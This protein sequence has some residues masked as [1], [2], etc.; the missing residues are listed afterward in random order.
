MKCCSSRKEWKNVL[1]L[2]SYQLWLFSGQNIMEIMQNQLQEGVEKLQTLQKQQQ[3]T[4][5]TRQLLDSQLNE[6][7]LVKE[8]MDKVESDA[9]V[10]K[11][12]GPAL[13]RQDVSE[14]KSN[15]DKRIS[16][17]TGELKRQE[18]LL[19]DLDKQQ[20]AEREKLQ[21]LQMQMQKL[22]QA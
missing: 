16:Y 13:V 21:A 1:K 4:L 20:E 15:V 17:I 5:S 19:A 7:K 3:K 2:K 11:L 9:K 12:I 6:N 8:E 22:A 18:D 14:A 10:Y